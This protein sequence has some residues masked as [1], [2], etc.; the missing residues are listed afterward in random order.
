MNTLKGLVFM[1]VITYVVAYTD[2]DVYEKYNC[3]FVGEIHEDCP[4]LS[5]NIHIIKPNITTQ[6]IFAYEET[7]LCEED[8]EDL[9]ITNEFLCYYDVNNNKVINEFLY[10]LATERNSEERSD[11]FVAVAIGIASGLGF[12]MVIAFT[13][14]TGIRNKRVL[15]QES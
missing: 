10:Q 11:N 9:L 15:M 1:M 6:Q 5:G 14:N 12:I 13:I 4:N 2:L 8:Y 3:R 7:E